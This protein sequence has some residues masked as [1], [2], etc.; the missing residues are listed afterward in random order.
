MTASTR[1]RMALRDRPEFASKPR[2]LT[3]PAETMTSEAVAAMSDKSFGSVVV[4]DGDNKVTGHRDRAR[5]HEE[6]RQRRVATRPRHRCP[7]S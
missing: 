3:F 4:V 6:D 5:H 1:S 2:P 7:R